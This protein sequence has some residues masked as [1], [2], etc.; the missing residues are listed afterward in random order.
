MIDA[1]I[2]ETGPDACGLGQKPGHRKRNLWQVSA[3]ISTATAFLVGALL[4]QQHWIT[5]DD[6]KDQVRAESDMHAFNSALATLQ[7]ASR[8][9]GNGRVVEGMATS[10]MAAAAIRRTLSNMAG[11]DAVSADD[12]KE[13]REV[14]DESLRISHEIERSILSLDNTLAP[15]EQARLRR[16]QQLRID[17]LHGVG[18]VADLKYRRLTEELRTQLDAAEAIATQQEYAAVAAALVAMLGLSLS[19]VSAGRANSR[20][21]HYVRNLKKSEEALTDQAVELTQVNQRLEVARQAAERANTA[22]S[23]FLANMSH[24][25][26][27]PMN[28]VIG[29]TELLC[30]EELPHSEQ[31]EHLQTIRNSGRHL[32]TLINDILDLSRI[33]AGR[34]D[35]KREECSPREIIRD[36]LSVMRVRAAD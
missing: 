20:L 26:R 28:A 30:R 25:I 35:F 21:D 33:E 10:R 3:T 29:F 14:A 5:Q 32:L 6:I 2:S 9:T 7:T 17:R 19:V 4:F 15:A 1:S 31:R 34:L 23:E 22:K 12:V 11:N 27:T 13:L 36:V 24:E 8:L 16:S 18:Q